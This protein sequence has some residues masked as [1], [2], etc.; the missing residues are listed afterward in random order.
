MNAVELETI[1]LEEIKRIS[2]LWVSRESC[3]S[4][5]SPNRMKT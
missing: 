5:D 3:V 2:F 1:G 4:S